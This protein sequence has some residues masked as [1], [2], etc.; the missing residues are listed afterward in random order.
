MPRLKKLNPNPPA[1]LKERIALLE[2]GLEQSIQAM[3]KLAQSFEQANG[4]MSIA[5]SIED[6]QPQIENQ[7]PPLESLEQV[8]GQLAE[9]AL[10]KI[11]KLEKIL[12]TAQTNPFGTTDYSIFE[13][14]IE[15]KTVASLQD[16][17]QRVGVN[18]WDSLPVLKKNLKT[19]FIQTN[20]Q[21]TLRE[22]PKTKGVTL[23]PRNPKH[24]QV[25][26]SLGMKVG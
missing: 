9:T 13:S 17:A 12:S 26:Q 22:R 4:Q 23:D 10:D 6:A 1:T 18:P 25:M 7:P 14:S 20:S 15:N 16:L 8:N 24:L 11:K 19:A 3:N 21:G 5:S 2:K